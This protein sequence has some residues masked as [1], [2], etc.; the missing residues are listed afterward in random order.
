M[1]HTTGTEGK[2]TKEKILGELVRILKRNV[3]GGG[4]I[5][6]SDRVDQDGLYAI[7]EEMSK[8][9]AALSNEVTGGP[10]LLAK[11]FPAVF[12]ATPVK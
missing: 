6:T 10:Q 1:A 4:S 7:Q 9:L 11:T 12:T 5:L 2:M 3:S 8:F